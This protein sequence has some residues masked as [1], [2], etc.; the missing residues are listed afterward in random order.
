[1]CFDIQ[2]LLHYLARFLKKICACVCTAPQPIVE[3]APVATYFIGNLTQFVG[4][5]PRNLSEVIESQKTF[6]RKP[7]DRFN[8]VPFS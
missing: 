5:R 1:M 2:R 7:L 3:R 6:L 4:V 8:K